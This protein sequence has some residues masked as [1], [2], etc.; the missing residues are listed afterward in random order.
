M[1]AARRGGCPAM[2]AVPAAGR[3]GPS[4]HAA[5]RRHRIVDLCVRPQFGDLTAGRGKRTMIFFSY[6]FCL[7][8]ILKTVVTL[9]RLQPRRRFHHATNCIVTFVRG[10][11]MANWTGWWEQ[12]G[13]GRRTM[14]NLVLDVAANGVVK[15][16][17]DDCIGPFTFAGQF[18]ADGTVSLIKQYIGRHWV[19]YEGLN[20][21][22]GIFG[23]WCISGLWTGKFA[24]RP[25]AESPAAHDEIQELAPDTSY[26]RPLLGIGGR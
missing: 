25:I 19:S 13:L 26:R 7:F 24:L 15:G 12:R 1:P 16:G 9:H 5:I 22:E 3:S 10:K 4:L 18:R 8:R 23:T 21:G 17:G 11:I 2:I 6:I 14:H 20:S